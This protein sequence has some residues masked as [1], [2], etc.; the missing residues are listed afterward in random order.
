MHQQIT[1]SLARSRSKWQT[2]IQGIVLSMDT[3]VETEKEL[4]QK[5]KKKVCSSNGHLVKDPV[6]GTVYVMQGD[7]RDSIKAYLLKIGIPREN[8][9]ESG[10]K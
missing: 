1:I 9:I 5:L 3:T 4:L 7:H 8:I 6:Q 10:T 2:V